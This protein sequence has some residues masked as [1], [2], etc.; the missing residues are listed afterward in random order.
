MFLTNKGNE[1]FC[2]QMNF[3]FTNEPICKEVLQ[4]LINHQYT[5]CA[6]REQPQF[7]SMNELTSTM[8]ELMDTIVEANK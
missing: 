8:K 7:V 3:T 2:K 5:L 4:A 1:L 6:E